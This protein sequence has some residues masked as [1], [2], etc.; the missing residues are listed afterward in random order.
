VGVVLRLVHYL[1]TCSLSVDES[2]LA[3]N[4]FDRSWEELFVHLDGAQ[5]AP[6]LFLLALKA[7]SLTLGES[8]ASL[9]LPALLAGVA[10]MFLFRSL[11]I[12]TLSASAASFSAGL[13][14]S[15][16]TSSRGDAPV[17]SW[18]MIKNH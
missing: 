9:R 6:V 2:L 12:R 13:S 8:E 1:Q 14:S 7:V 15:A 3:L 10:S 17:R 4:I 18:S 11:A 16:L 5:G